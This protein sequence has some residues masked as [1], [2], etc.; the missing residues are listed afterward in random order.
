[1][2]VYGKIKTTAI[3]LEP[4]TPGSMPPGSIFNDSTNSNAFT[5]KTSAGTISPIGAT[6]S[7]DYLVKYK[8][9][10]SGS[11]L[12]AYK[13]V[14]LHADGTIVLADSDNPTA[15][16]D[17]GMTLDAVDHNT[18]GRILLN[19]ANAPGALTGL[20]FAVGDHIFLSKTPGALTN[21]AGAF[22][23]NTDTIM[24][25]GIADCATNTA[26]ATATDLIMTVEVYSSPGGA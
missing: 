14:A 11:T 12:P 7:A 18:F 23:P 1:M 15:M 24:R 3:I 21:N 16:L 9:N 5:N 8:K 26:G 2:T 10:M 19:S 20:G 22:D 4:T 25:V 13:R 17:I 6:S